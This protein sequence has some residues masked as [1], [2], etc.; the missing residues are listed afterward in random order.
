MCV[1]LFECNKNDSNKKKKSYR[2]VNHEFLD[3]TQKLNFKVRS[4]TQKFRYV[5]KKGKKY[6]RS[7]QRSMFTVLQVERAHL[8]RNKILF[9]FLV[10]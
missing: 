1:G 10:V 6:P 4:V 3:M 2:V 7:N 9:D 5:H 8:R